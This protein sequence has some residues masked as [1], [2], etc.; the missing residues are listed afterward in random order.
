[1]H[2][3][4][5]ILMYTSSVY[6]CIAP[7]VI[8]GILTCR[9][10]PERGVTTFTQ[11]DVP[12]SRMSSQTNL[13]GKSVQLRHGRLSVKAIYVNNASSHTL[14]YFPWQSKPT[15]PLLL[16]WWKCLYAHYLTNYKHSR[17]KYLFI[18]KL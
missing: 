11:V 12:S 2:S 13:N 3:C 4:I 17:L 7:V 6:I 14:Y 8:C 15:A 1:M 5:V 9:Q 16:A 18:S 10:W